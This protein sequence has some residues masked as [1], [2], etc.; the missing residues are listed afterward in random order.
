MDEG[1]KQYGHG[2]AQIGIKGFMSF[3]DSRRQLIK[4]LDEEYIG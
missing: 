2:H 3:K 1:E 4:K